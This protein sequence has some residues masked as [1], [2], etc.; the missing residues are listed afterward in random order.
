MEFNTNFDE[1]F[2][3]GISEVKKAVIPVDCTMILP[4]Y[5]PDVMKIL[6]YTAKTV[7]SPV[8]FDGSAEIVSGNVNI[9]VNYVSE[10]GELCYCSQLQPFSHSFVCEKSSVAADAE[11]T[12]GEIGCRA[13]NKRRI[14]LHGNIDVALRTVC[15]DEEKMLSFAQGAGSVCRS[16]S[17]DTVLMVGEFYKSFTLEERGEL[18]NGKTDFGK[19]LRVSASAQVTECHVI[20]DK[21]VTK[22]KV[23]IEVL[24]TG[25]NISEDSEGGPFLSKFS[26]PVSRMVDAKGIL[27]T[28]ICDA[29]YEADFPEISPSD[30][31][32]N[33]IIK[34][35]IGIFARVYRR[36][37]SNFVS[38]MFST[39]Y[40]TKLEKKKITVIDSA[41][42]VA[43]TDTVFEK[44][45]L[46]ETVESVTD[47]WLENTPP[48]ALENGK[49]SYTA[50]VCL[51]AK[52]PDGTPIYFERMLERECVSPSEERNIAFFNL[53]PRTESLEYTLTGDRK[54]EISAS[55]LID[56]TIYTSLSTDV[57]KNCTVSTERKFEH[58]DVALLFCFADK[59][60]SVWDIAKKY[61]VSTEKIAAENEI[62]EE[63]FS[64]KTMLVISR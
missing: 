36:E 23:D 27:L 15:G 38:D 60:E 49:I 51:F 4:D 37:T 14:D 8:T 48:K 64:E 35:K 22:G 30:D 2:C 31:G 26:Y 28:D 7:K 57:I 47:M 62:S 3:C 19:T 52:D 42:A 16:K 54:A 44:F 24:W 25:D 41:F 5:F 12:V 20:Q 56:G 46:P 40:E 11:I 9:E 63:V 43:V 32:Q 55:V 33:I 58:E 39:E 17:I 10:D 1:V 34:V 18:E 13:V 6:R 21:I 29:S 61:G 45:E 53:T 50:R 59:G